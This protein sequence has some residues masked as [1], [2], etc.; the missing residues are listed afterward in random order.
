[1]PN[2]IG[3]NSNAIFLNALAR[4]CCRSSAEKVTAPLQQMEQP[5]SEGGF[6]VGPGSYQLRAH[7]SDV[8]PMSRCRTRL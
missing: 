1:L 5:V 8:R 2:P 6:D 3:V 4:T 7:Y